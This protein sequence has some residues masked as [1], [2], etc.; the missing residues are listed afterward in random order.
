MS[1]TQNPDITIFPSLLA[2]TIEYLNQAKLGKLPNSLFDSDE[3]KKCIGKA[4]DFYGHMFTQ[5]VEVRLNELGWNTQ[6]ELPLKTLGGDS[7]LGDIDVLAWQPITCRVIVIECKSLMADRTIGEIGERLIEFS[8]KKVDGNFTQLQKHLNRFR[9]LKTY[10]KKLSDF[11]NISIDQMEL[12]SALVT[13]KLSP[14]Q[15]GGEA[16]DKLDFVID[17]EQIE[18]VLINKKEWFRH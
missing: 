4:A 14:M 8:D 7:S 17:F 6:L 2:G 10:A 5:K 18:G 1:F 12:R 11:T 3:M 13:E 15:F 16:R 9:F